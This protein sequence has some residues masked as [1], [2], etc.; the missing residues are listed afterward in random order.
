[1]FGW[2][3]IRARPGLRELLVFFAV[4]NFLWAMVGALITPMILSWTASEGLG[5]IISTAGL[6]MLAGSRS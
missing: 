3:Y 4:V 1:M 2:R 6:G 5:L